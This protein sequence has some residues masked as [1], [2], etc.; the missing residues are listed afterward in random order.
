MST[1]REILALASGA[2]VTAVALPTPA[3]AGGRD[4]G[5]A[6]TWAAAPTTIPPGP[7]LELTGQTVRQVVHTSVGGDQLRIR[8]TNEFGN[9]PL[10]VGE[11]HV[12]IRAGSGASTD[13]RPGTDRRVT[14]S[15]Q[16]SA[17]VPAGA[18][19]LSDPVGLSVAPGADLVISL[20][21]PD[22]TP[23]T[24][25]AAFAFQENAIA[26]GNVTGAARITATSTITQY[27][28]LSGVSVRS[29]AGTA[30]TLG[31]SI[32]NGANT[33]TNANHRWPDLLAA[34]FRKAGIRLGVA[35]VGVSGNRLLHDPNPPAGDPAE[36]FAAY[37]AQSALRR[38][39]RDVLA[40]PGARHLVV[41]LGVNDLGHPGTVAPPSEVVTAA[42]LI[43]GH[44]QL[45]ARARQAGLRTHGATILPFKGDTLGFF[46]PENERK[47]SALNRWI[48]T[49]G[50]YDEVI[51]FDAA[52]R[53]TADPLRL[54]PAYDSGDHL[55][56]NDA[57]M[58]AMAAAI[59]LS[60]FQHP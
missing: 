32:T 40:Q 58:A 1:R 16:R 53:D 59:R 3:A 7:P 54:A 5:W 6:A 52:V 44:R 34:R 24:T 57:G 28:F 43:A 2:A 47:R 18:P 35:N 17:T 31:D 10:H 8:L 22:R 26:A 11:V 60:G 51:D 4:D 19:L 49:S 13:A 30:V 42:D 45:I 39:D 48:R 15:G 29:G 50:E 36:T 55:H 46:T 9:T 23:V 27:L 37:F 25:L 33:E 41:L 21:L 56:P 38:F 14:F 20:Y 12:A